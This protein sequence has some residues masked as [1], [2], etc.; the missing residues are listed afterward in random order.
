MTA[1]EDILDLEREREQLE[2]TYQ[3]FLDRLAKINRFIRDLEIQMILEENLLNQAK[4]KVSTVFTRILLKVDDMAKDLPAIHKD[5]FHQ[6][7]GKISIELD[8]EILFSTD[9]SGKVA[10]E[11]KDKQN[12]PN[13]RLLAWAKKHDLVLESSDVQSKIEFFNKGLQEL[14]ETEKIILEMIE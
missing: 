2:E 11:C 7:I 4:W 10:L 1:R 14:Q 6:K 5:V 12:S 13:E 3:G 9:E 8:N